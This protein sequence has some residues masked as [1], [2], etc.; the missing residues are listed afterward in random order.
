MEQF[1]I[2]WLHTAASSHIHYV[3]P[4]CLNHFIWIFFFLGY[5]IKMVV[6]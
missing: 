2:S 5:P 1:I 6:V 3:A 4:A